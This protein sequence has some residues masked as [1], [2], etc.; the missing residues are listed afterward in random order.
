ML[1]AEEDG[2]DP[3]EEIRRVVEEAVIEGVVRGYDLTV[4]SSSSASAPVKEEESQGSS[5]HGPSVDG[6]KA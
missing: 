4:S 3:E 6:P 1:R 5:D 2:H